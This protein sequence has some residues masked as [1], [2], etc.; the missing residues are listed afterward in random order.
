MRPLQLR[1]KAGPALTFLV[2]ILRADPKAVTSPALSAANLC[3]L[4]ASRFDLKY[5]LPGLTHDQPMTTSSCTASGSASYSANAAC[6]AAVRGRG[7]PS[8]VRW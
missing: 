8:G 6:I 4:G 7:G 5:G 2:V 1:W 3:A